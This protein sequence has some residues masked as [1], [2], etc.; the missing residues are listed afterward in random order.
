MHGGDH[1]A[2]AKE[3]AIRYANRLPEKPKQNR[4][5]AVVHQAEP[6]KELIR[7]TIGLDE[8]VPRRVDWLYENRIAPGFISLFAG[9]SGLGKSFVT[10]DIVARF[11]RGEPAPYSNLSRPAMRTMFISEDSPEIVIGPRLI[12]LK[13]DRK[14]V[15]FMTWEAMAAY[16]LGDTAML[17]RAYQECGRPGLIVIDPPANFLGSVDEHK[18]AEVRAVLKTLIAWLDLHRVAA[19]LITHINKQLGKGMDAV[20]RIM[21]SVAWGTTARITCA[22]TK[23]PDAR[24]QFLFGGTKN[25]LGEVADTL[26]YKI[27]KTEALAT[28]QW[29]GKTDTTMDDAIDQVKKKSKGKSAVEW[30]EE[31]F[32]EKREWESVELRS[33]GKEH[34][35]T[36][37][38]LFESPEVLALPIKKRKRMNANGEQYWVWQAEDGWPIGQSE[39]SESSESCN[40]Y[41]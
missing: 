40:G 41:H 39:S 14:M 35:I 6:P 9:R 21:G 17:D 23:D 36:S 10:C 27:V 3:L 8:I 2:A 25:N 13:A 37:Y 31:R 28:V 26:M 22:F 18:N 30:L 11:S 34:G 32:R 7:L 4:Q 5:P 16:T 19:V 20:E 24:G 33:M 12:E 1:H 38:A 29:E 15:R